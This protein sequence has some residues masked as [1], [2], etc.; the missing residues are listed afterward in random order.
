MGEAHRRPIL[1]RLF[2]LVIFDCDG[3]LVDSEP[4]TCGVMAVALT[5]IGLAKT[6]AQCMRDYVG[7]WWPDVVERVEDELGRPL[8]DG[9]TEEYRRRQN[10][11][12]AAECSP[13][14]GAVEALDLVEAAGAE[15]CVASN[16]PHSKMEVTLGACGLLERFAGRIFSA[17]DVAR[18]KPAPDLFLHAAAATGHDPAACAVVEDSPLGIEAARAAG[19]SA[20]GFSADSDPAALEAAGAVAFDSM[21]RLGELL[22]AR[23]DGH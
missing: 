9:F 18:G 23:N 15:T 13:V 20:L 14:A 16:G 4:V 8:P 5:E 2:E 21:R 12:L 11:A 7:M 1:A 10:A 3:V 17:A 6:T 19:M 22:G